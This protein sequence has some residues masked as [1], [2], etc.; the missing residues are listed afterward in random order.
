MKWREQRD[1]TG[2]NVCGKEGSLKDDLRNK[3]PKN[4]PG[5]FY[6]LAKWN[7]QLFMLVAAVQLVSLSQTQTFCQT[8][9]Y[10]LRKS[11]QGTSDCGQVNWSK[12]GGKGFKDQMGRKERWK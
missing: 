2:I 8:E 1:G 12:G 9:I 3:A 4:P 5:G 10:S 7:Y 6:S 11:P